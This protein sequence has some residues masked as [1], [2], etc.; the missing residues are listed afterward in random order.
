MARVTGP[1]VSSIQGVFAENWVECVGEILCGPEYFPPLGKT[2]DTSTI[3]VKSSPAD[4]ATASRVLFQT[5]IEGAE[6]SVRIST[7]YFLPDKAFRRA[8]MRVLARRVPVTAIVP[9]PVTDQKFLRLASRRSAVALLAVTNDTTSPLDRLGHKEENRQT[10]P[11][12]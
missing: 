7:P 5:L 1:V 4:R 10:P 8:L 9:G 11:R 3:V 6:R 12:L 2:G